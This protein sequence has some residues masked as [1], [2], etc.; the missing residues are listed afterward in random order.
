M[1]KTKKL[2]KLLKSDCG[3]CSSCCRDIKVDVTGADLERLVKHTGIPADKLVKMYSPADTSDEE[4]SDWIELSYGKR[5]LEL[6]KRRNGDCV[7]LAKD[8]TCTAYDA[9]PMTCRIFP[10]CVVSDN[11][12][13]IVA[14]EISDVITD[15]TIKCKRTRGKGRSYTSFMS[16]AEQSQIEDEIFKKKVD[17][18]NDLHSNGMKNDFLNFL[19]FKT[20]K[21][22]S[23]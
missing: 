6:N 5:A 15:R 21:N 17:E 8:K 11:R 23:R 9:R 14:L 7:F 18:W 12:N 1:K 19:G 4:E 22:G 10:V 16:T 2:S 13:N 3:Q 20:S